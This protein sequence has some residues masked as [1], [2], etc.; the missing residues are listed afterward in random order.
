M[1]VDVPGQPRAAAV[2]RGAVDR[3]DAGH[4]WAFVGPP[5]VGQEVAARRFAAALNG[6]D[7]PRERDG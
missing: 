3:D 7:Q 2:L 4:A 6:A 5:G 1:T